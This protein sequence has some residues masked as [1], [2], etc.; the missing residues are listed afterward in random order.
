M[1]VDSMN[2]LKRVLFAVLWFLLAVTFE[3]A[4]ICGCMTCSGLAVL[5]ALAVAGMFILFCRAA[6]MVRGQSHGSIRS[7]MKS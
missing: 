5:L 7:L 1:K 2:T 3:A 4:I 6:F